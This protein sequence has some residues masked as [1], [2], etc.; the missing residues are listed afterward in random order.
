MLAVL[1]AI[2]RR[3]VNPALLQT[4][5]TGC[6]VLLIAFMLFIAF[7]DTGDWIRSAR[8]NHEAPVVFGHR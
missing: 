4:V 6:A 1:E 7:F 8:E 5:Q 2:R 3:P